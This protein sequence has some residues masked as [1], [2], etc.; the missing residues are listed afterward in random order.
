MN[1]EISNLTEQI[2]NKLQLPEDDKQ[3]LDDYLSE[4]IKLLIKNKSLSKEIINDFIFQK[5]IPHNIEVEKSVISKLLLFPLKNIGKMSE[6]TE[7]YFYDSVNSHIW[8]AI[9]YLQESN[10]TINVDGLYSVLES[11]NKIDYVGGKKYIESLIKSQNTDSDFDERL[12][13]LANYFV[14]RSM[15]QDLQESMHSILDKDVAEIHDF[16]RKII[17]DLSVYSKNQIKEI[18]NGITL[19]NQFAEY[20]DKYTNSFKNG[21]GITGL[22]TCIEELDKEIKGWQETDLI[23]IAGRP[24]MGKTAFAISDAV[25]S[26]LKNEPIL[27]FSLEM[28]ALQLVVRM[29]TIIKKVSLGFA[30]EYRQNDINSFIAEELP[31]LPIYIDDTPGVNWKY[32]LDKSILYKEKFGIKRIYVDYLQLMGSSEQ[33]V[34]SR[35]QIVSENS[36][37]LKIVAKTTNCP[38]FNLSQL[39]R[40]CETRVDK[41]PLLSDLRDSGSIEQDADIVLFTYRDEYYKIFESDARSNT[42]GIAEIIISKNRNGALNTINC[43]FNAPITKWD[44]LYNRPLSYSNNSNEYLKKKA[45]HVT[46]DNEIIDD[47]PF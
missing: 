34:F 47:I 17:E 1:R 6:V 43:F 15:Y 26:V 9:K 16:R 4:K 22:S 18:N 32:I 20:V 3:W 14:A 5:K 40:S 33:K 31:N 11:M 2:K 8:K 30:I 35:E 12:D 27:F 7:D 29:F 25:H 46:D 19:A 21:K 13:E 28:S 24:G 37:G 36:R 23:V 10:K 39:S 41:R 42:E 45:Q 44:N 38:V